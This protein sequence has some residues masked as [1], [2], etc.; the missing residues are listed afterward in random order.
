MS[1]IDN[2]EAASYT[3]FQR[4]TLLSVAFDSIRHGL[5]HNEPLPVDAQV[6][7]EALRAHRA[8]FV[9]LKLNHELR[10]CIGMLEACRPL[11]VDVAHNAYA[12]AFSDPRFPHLNEH[13]ARRVSIHVS[14]L[15]PPEPMPVRSEQDLLEKLRPHIDG[16]ILTDGIYRGTFL[17][18]VW[19]SLPDPHDFLQALKRKAGLPAHYWSATLRVERYR[20]VVIE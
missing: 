1:S 20:A 7:D 15:T 12:A 18:S 2:D 9:T 5:I 8:T 10:G 6:F 4:E 19:E 13:E 14:I 11:V 16:V 17:P 3:P